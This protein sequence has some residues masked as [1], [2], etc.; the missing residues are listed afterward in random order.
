MASFRLS[1]TALAL[2]ELL[3]TVVLE[4]VCSKEDDHYRLF[5]GDDRDFNPFYVAHT[6]IR[7]LALLDEGNQGANWLHWRARLQPIRTA[8]EV[9]ARIGIKPLICMPLYQKLAGKIRGLFELGMTV[10]D[11]ARSLQI[12]KKTVRKA[13]QFYN[14]TSVG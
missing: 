11:I 7:T 13:R 10:T 6:K 12:A 5:G 4:P 3:G 8:A 1:P 14:K 2:K 9:N